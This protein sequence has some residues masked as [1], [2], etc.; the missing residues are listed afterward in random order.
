MECTQA[1]F[2]VLLHNP[3]YRENHYIDYK[4]DFSFL[5]TL[6][7]KAPKEKVLAKITDFRND[8]CAFANADGGYIIYGIRDNEGT[9]AELIGVE[10]DNPDKFELDLRNKLMPIMP[11]IP[12]VT[13][14]FLHLDNGRYLVIAFI[15][16]DYYAPYIHI[17]EQKN[18]KIYKRNGNGNTVIN[19]T[20]LKNMFVQSRVLEDEILQFRKQRI[21]Y[22]K[23]LDD[24]K[25]ERF[26]LFQMIP[27]SFQNYRIPLFIRERQTHQ[28]FG[29][30]FSGT[31]IDSHSF[32]WM[33]CDSFHLMEIAKQ[34]YIIPEYQ[35]FF[36][37]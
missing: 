28:S 23:D 11:K 5:K 17:E 25:F 26:M 33:D 34:S 30:V 10:M 18:F 16:H 6:K 14:R 3:D 8:I 2:E 21:N 15:E 29:A 4:E 9:A 27:E 35:S 32:P 13:F 37:R 19:Y 20:E 12:P 36:F 22:Y 1:D 7:E 31:N 24:K